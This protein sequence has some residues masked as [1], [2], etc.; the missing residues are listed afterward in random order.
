VDV[1][2]HWLFGPYGDFDRS[3]TVDM[4]DMTQFVDYWLVADCNELA[5][6]DYNGDCKVNGYE[7]SLLAKNWLYIPPDTTPPAVPSGFWATG[8][9]GTVT[10][11][12]ND[13][14]EPDFAG[15][16]IYRSTTHGSG[17][18]KLNSSLLTS[19]SYADNTVTNGTIY[20]YVVTAKDITGNESANS[21]EAC[22]LP[23]S[24]TNI[25]LQE[26]TTG[27]CSV[28]GAIESEWAGYTGAGYANTTN[29]TG[30]GVD[31]RISVQSSGTYSFVW[32]YA[33]VTGDRTAKLIINGATVVPSISFPA[34]GAVTTYIETSTVD[35]SIS[36]GINDIR[37]EATTSDGLGNIDYLKVT[38]INPQAAA[39]Q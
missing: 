22:A 1:F 9:D 3:G 36:A 27:F 31:W 6:A 35:V 30:A 13:N 21:V 38:G 25:M 17:Y 5:D 7:F 32:R 2:P 28:D 18:T 24:A 26:N 11:E 16:N 10:L 34:S 33:I 39:C 23:G 12:W 20:Y 14:N 15:Y 37:L 8:G 29:A 4:K 19:S